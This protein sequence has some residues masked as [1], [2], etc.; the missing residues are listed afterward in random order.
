MNLAEWRANK[1]VKMTLQS[2]L[3]VTLKRAS[4][5]DLMANGK[6][7]NTMLGMTEELARGG[8]DLNLK[9]LP[10]ATA[11]IDLV[12]KICLVEPAV[13]DEPDETHITLDE[14][15]FNDRI[16]IFG[17]ANQ[18]ALTAAPFREEPGGDVGA[19][20]PGDGVRTEAE[21]HPGN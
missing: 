1:T 19:V 12:A 7:P 15:P 10:A 5:L 17:W 6:I 8:K 11:V 2:G 21:Q 20:Q 3:E 16:E 9:E 14:L 13:G 4:L 18:G